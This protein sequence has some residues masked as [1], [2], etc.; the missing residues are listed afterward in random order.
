MLMLLKKCYLKEFKGKARLKI[1][2]YNVPLK[3]E[4]SPIFY[5]SRDSN[6]GLKLQTWLKLETIKYAYGGVLVFWES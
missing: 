3:F 4:R 5:R 2:D 6:S 1:P